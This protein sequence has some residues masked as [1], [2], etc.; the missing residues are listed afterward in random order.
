MTCL[1]EGVLLAVSTEGRVR[2]A[3]HAITSAPQPAGVVQ[4]LDQGGG[5]VRAL[6]GIVDRGVPKLQGANRRAMGEQGGEG[7]GKEK[8]S[9][10]ARND[11]IE[12]YMNEV[13]APFR[14]QASNVGAG[15]LGANV[16]PQKQLKQHQ[17][18]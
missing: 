13:H 10:D 16:L 3:E 4:A 2:V 1:V 5:L 14:R 18:R 7:K 15:A 6:N 11:I 17:S 8:A 12:F 9:A